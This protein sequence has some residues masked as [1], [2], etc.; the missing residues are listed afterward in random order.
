MFP[1]RENNMK[2][3][4]DHEIFFADNDAYE[5]YMERE[6]FVPLWRMGEVRGDKCIG[7]EGEFE[8]KPTKDSIYKRH[9]WFNASRLGKNTIRFEA[10]I[11]RVKL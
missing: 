5:K 4:I 6:G 3:V 2:N 1:E 7:A 8:T 10:T 9:F 11:T